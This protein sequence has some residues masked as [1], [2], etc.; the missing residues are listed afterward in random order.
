MI[1]AKLEV[2]GT[3]VNLIRVVCYVEQYQGTQTIR[4]KAPKRYLLRTPKL[5]NQPFDVTYDLE[6]PTYF[7]HGAVYLE[8]KKKSLFFTFMHLLTEVDLTKLN[9]G[10]RIELPITSAP[11]DYK[12]GSVET[13]LTIEEEHFNLPKELPA[14]KKPRSPFFQISLKDQDHEMFMQWFVLFKAFK[15]ELTSNDPKDIKIC[16]NGLL[17]QPLDYF[18]K[19]DMYRKLIRRDNIYES[20]ISKTPTNMVNIVIPA[21]FCK[22][23]CDLD[24]DIHYCVESPKYED[25]WF[26]PH[27]AEK[28][29]F[30][31]Q[32]SGSESYLALANKFVIFDENQYEICSIEPKSY[33]IDEMDLAQ[34]V[35]RNLQVQGQ[36]AKQI[37]QELFNGYS[38]K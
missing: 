17:I 9:A 15:N 11:G 25:D 30:P 4:D 7:T 31:Y 32:F 6:I 1:K 29:V 22:H 14:D 16:R 35:R 3:G 18:D 34:I 2:K 37:I 38:S 13:Y 24:F 21:F 28:G 36:V 10:E 8:Y 19:V 5:S 23:S 20:G 33:F 27:I 26:Q 12:A